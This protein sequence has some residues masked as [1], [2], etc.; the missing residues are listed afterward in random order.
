[1]PTDYLAQYRQA[2]TD[3]NHDFARTILTTAVSAAQAG[4][5]GPHQIR[6]LVEE[7]KANPPK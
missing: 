1:M 3:G 7:A 4:A 5:I 6:A 2:I